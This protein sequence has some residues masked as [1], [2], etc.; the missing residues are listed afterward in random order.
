[1]PKTARQKIVDK[2]DK[3]TSEIVRTRDRKCVVCG[4]KSKL[5]SGHVFSRK[6]YSTRW[7]ITNDGNVHTQCWPCNFRHTRDQYPYFKWYR[8]KFGDDAFD[9]LR[10]RFKAIAK[11]K[12]FELEEL[13]ER[14]K[15]FREIISN[16]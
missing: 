10:Y 9:G 15:A 13:Y 3:I 2:L 5:G 1:M 7:D 11:Y 16:K 8:A 14:L 6:A 12:T 4:G